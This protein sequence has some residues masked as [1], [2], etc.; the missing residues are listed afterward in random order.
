MK[1]HLAILTPGWI[2]G[3]KT[4]ESRFTKVCAPYG[5]VNT[6]DVVY[7]KESGGKGQFAASGNFSFLATT[8]YLEYFLQVSFAWDYPEEVAS[9]CLPHKWMVSQYA[10]LI[11]IADVIAYEHPFPY[12]KRQSAWL[13]RNSMEKSQRVHIMRTHGPDLQRKSAG[14]TVKQRH[15]SWDNEKR[16][17]DLRWKPWSPPVAYDQE[18]GTP[19]GYS[20]RVSDREFGESIY[21]PDNKYG[22][23]VEYC[24]DLTVYW[25]RKTMEV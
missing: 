11:H 24:V 8:R 20:S 1:Y 16:T 19:I 17:K 14:E 4:I 25:N 12:R 13:H 21:I 23:S 18:D 2:D 6:G 9:Y 22:K 3:S 15:Q 10:T 7:L 5:K